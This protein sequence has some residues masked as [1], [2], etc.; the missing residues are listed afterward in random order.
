MSMRK[1]GALDPIDRYETL[2]LMD[3]A[4]PVCEAND[5]ERLYALFMRDYVEAHQ[6]KATD[7][8]RVIDFSPSRSFSMFMRSLPHMRYRAVGIQAAPHIDDGSADLTHLYNY[9][10]DSF[11][12][13]IC[14]HVLEHVS[15]AEAG[16]RELHRITRPGGL[17]IAMVP[18]PLDLDETVDDPRWTSE[19]DR[20]KYYGQAD[21]LRMF[22]KSGF[23]GLLENTGFRVEELGERHFGAGS[24]RRFGISSRS[25]LYVVEK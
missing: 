18:I 13:F 23:R 9:A 3:Y 24:F 20:W 19:A 25:V 11:D 10:T 22:S 8:L 16:A 4:C 6:A 2:N 21:H 12:A 1:H 17:G 5:R 14:S 15:D 7:P